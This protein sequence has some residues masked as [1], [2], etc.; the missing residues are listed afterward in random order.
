[1]DFKSL[2]FLGFIFFSVAVYRVTSQALYRPSLMLVLN[3]T[4]LVCFAQN[5]YQL[6][7]LFILL[8][9]GYLM[10]YLVQSKINIERMS[11]WGILTIVILFI[12]LK[13]YAFIKFIPFFSFSVI[14]I[15]L[16]FILFRIIHLLVDADSGK[17]K[18]RISPV[19]FFNYTCFF[20]TF[21][22]GPIQSYK[23]F[24]QSYRTDVNTLSKKEVIQVISR[25]LTGY[26]K[27]ILIAS[28]CFKVHGLCLEQIQENQEGMVELYSLAAVSYTFFLYYNFAGYM[29]IVISLGK[30]IGFDLPENF[31]RPFAAPN[32]LQFWSRWHMTLSNWFKVYLFNPLLKFLTYKYPD[33]KT[34]P[35]LG[36][37]SFS[38]KKFVAALVTFFIMGIWHGS[39]QAFTAFGIFLGLGA[40]LNKLYQVWV[41]NGFGKTQ[42]L[43]ISENWLY[44]CTCKGLTF[45]YFCTA[46]ICFW[47]NLTSLGEFY[48][49]AGLSGATLIYCEISFA[50]MVFFILASFFKPPIDSIIFALSRI[51]NQSAI[52]LFWISNKLF[53]IILVIANQ[54][55]PA[56]AFVY[57]FF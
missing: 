30:L 18:E 2:T 53:F 57:K 8:C 9:V 14:V 33:R 41:Q 26:V 37:V 12:Y 47:I 32:F 11:T 7:P 56:P 44:I 45:S 21:T 4:F 19:T 52:D 17:I 20:L 46:L 35:Y 23:D 34:S 38:W 1:M 6:A 55:I 36:A 49:K 39:T 5:F 3:L 27:V 24:S 22:S 31:N 15:G 28:F 40:S 48:Q 43:K 16:S 10:L 13:Q 25:L 42:Y 51:K 54:E 50:A 29:D